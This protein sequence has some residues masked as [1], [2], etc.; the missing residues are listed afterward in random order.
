MDFQALRA[1]FLDHANPEKAEG[2]RRYMRDQFEFIGIQTPLRRSLTKSFLKQ[3]K[4]SSELDWDFV[5]LCWND[6]YREFQYAAVDYLRSRQALL[7]ADDLYR[8]KELAQK[9]SWWDTIDG[10]DQ[11]VG[12][13]ALEYPEANQTLLQWS[14]DD[15]FWLRRIAI[16]HQL[17]RKNLTDTGLLETILLNNLNQTEFFI[18]KAIG[19]ALREYSKTDPD[20]V[21][22]FIEQ[23]RGSMSKLSIRE[24]SKYI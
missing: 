12:G 20:W 10:L 18:N 14:T 8:L 6:Q 3:Y 7:E 11:I 21:C 19:W 4:D 5:H 15:D 1:L 17:G 16:D 9:K 22:R 13:I 24:G 23:H 2:M